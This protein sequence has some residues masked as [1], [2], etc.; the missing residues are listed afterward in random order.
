[1]IEELLKQWHASFLDVDRIPFAIAAM[2]VTAIIGMISGPLFGNTYP[3]LWIVFDKLFGGLGDRLDKAQRQKA[4]L[5]F[6]GFL[7][8]AFA[9]FIAAGIGKAIDTILF[10]PEYGWV[11]ETIALSLIL[12]SGTVW[13]ALLKL[14]FAM[15]KDQVGKGAYYAIARSTRTNLAAAD[16]FAITRAA[17]NLSA[18]AFDK[19]LVAPIIWYVIL[20][21]PGAVI[22]SALSALSWRFGKDGFSK[23]F[24]SAAMALEKLLGFFP[25]VLSGILIT[26]AGIF[27]PTAKPHKGIAAWLGHKNRASYEQGGHPLSALAWSLNLSLGGAS[28]DLTGHAIKSTWVG[29]EGATAKNNHKHLRRAIYIHVLAYVLFIAVL[30]GMYLWSGVL[31]GAELKH[32]K[33]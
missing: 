4:D 15:D 29:P 23:G 24:G 11:I 10:I 22:Y 13:Y 1:M 12:T 19:G 21:M 9:I 14:Y 32:I 20:G 17:I 6:R 31:Q 18:R 2:L 5:M 33:L 30:L 7:V 28:Q 3:A 26:L 8:T 25:A 27:T 16:E